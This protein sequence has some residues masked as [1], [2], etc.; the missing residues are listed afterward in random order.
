ML[1]RYPNSD[2]KNDRDHNP[3]PRSGMDE[4]STYVRAAILYG[5]FRSLVIWTIG[6]VLVV[7]S[8]SIEWIRPAVPII[9]YSTLII[10]A[11]FGAIQVSRYGSEWIIERIV[12]PWKVQDRIYPE[13]AAPIPIDSPGFP[14]PRIDPIRL[15]AA[16]IERGLWKIATT[17]ITGGKTTRDEMERSGMKQSTWNAINRILTD[18]D[19]K[20][21]YTWTTNDPVFVIHA[22]TRID[23]DDT[24]DSYWITNGSHRTRIFFENP[25]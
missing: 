11:I 17:H 23:I 10:G 7:L 8:W 25:K 12:R 18:L 24:G 9:C 16:E 5:L 19:L 2:N 15:N 21:G 14:D 4:I 20:S 6:L 22:L 1:I 3:E 13:P